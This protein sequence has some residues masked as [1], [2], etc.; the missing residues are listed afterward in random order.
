M[1]FLSFVYGLFVA[2]LL[3]LIESIEIYIL[4]KSWRVKDYERILYKTYDDIEYD[5]KDIE[6]MGQ[7]VIDY[8]KYLRQKE[9]LNKFLNKFRK[10]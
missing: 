3:I 6:C 7:A 2:M 10:K 1:D 5:D 9:K 4:N 8:K